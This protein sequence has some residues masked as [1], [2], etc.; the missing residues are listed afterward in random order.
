[1]PA[2]Q[3]FPAACPA[4]GV[5]LAKVGAAMSGAT[6]SGVRPGATTP[7]SGAS[8]SRVQDHD[9]YDEEPPLGFFERLL[10]VPD[11]VDAA[12]LWARAVL[13]AAFVAWGFVLVGLDFREGEINGSFLHRPL[14]IFHEAG[15]VIF[16]PFGEWMTIFGGT[17]AQLLMPAVM[18]AALLWKNRD[19]F[20]ASLGL[21]LFGVSLLDVAPYIYDALHPQLILLSGGVGEEGGHDWLWLLGY[22][23]V[24]PKAQVYGAAVHKLGAAVIVLAVAWGAWVLLRQHA[25]DGA[26]GAGGAT[27]S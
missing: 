10:E 15:H 3:A 26:G 7:A 25:R 22:M 16:S 8:T 1:M 2:E 19:P 27:R 20:G 14:L 18:G 24:L 13:W 23:H 5:I 6:G 12:A 21:W 17:L 11:E 4:C 9:P